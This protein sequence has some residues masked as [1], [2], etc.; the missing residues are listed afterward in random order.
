V[1]RLVASVAV[2]GVALTACSSSTPEPF[3]SDAPIPGSVIAARVIADD[4]IFDPDAA[5]RPHFVPCRGLSGCARSSP[6]VGE[7]YPGVALR[8]NVDDEVDYTE[9]FVLY[10]AGAAFEQATLDGTTVHVRV[11]ARARGF[12]MVKLT[13]QDVLTVEPTF[14]FQTADG[15]VLCTSSWEGCSP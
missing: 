15:S 10:L 6:E 1:R 13:G 5:R 2:A 12:Q 3:R 11:S 14:S 8:A 9:Q 7:Y 4:P